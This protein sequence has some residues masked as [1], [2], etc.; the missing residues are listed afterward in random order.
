MA[1]DVALTMPAVTLFSKPNGEPIAMTHS[2]GRSFDGSPRRTVGRFFASI[3]STATSVRS[4]D[5]DDLRRVLATIGRL[6]RHLVRVRNDV[7]VRQD[8]AVLR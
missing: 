8:V 2:P 7:R 3:L 4:S 1:R 6:D 5:A